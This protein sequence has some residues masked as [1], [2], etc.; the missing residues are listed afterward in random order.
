[1]PQEELDALSR[2]NE[3]DI[4]F[5]PTPQQ[6]YNAAI[7]YIQA[8]ISILPVSTDGTKAPAWRLLPRVK[9]ED[10]PEGK[11]S[12]RVFQER[13]PTE[14]EVHSW[15]TYWGPTPGI[16][17]IGGA[18]SGGLGIID[19][20]SADL[21]TP[22]ADMVQSRLPGVLER[23]VF[24]QTPRPGL[25]GYYRCEAETGNEKLA[26]RRVVNP[27]TEGSEV[28]TLIET[29]GNGGYAIVP[30][31]PSWC[32][33]SGRR[34]FY[35]G[36]RDL[37]QV[38]VLTASE[39]DVLFEAGRRLNEIVDPP[40][41]C[42]PARISSASTLLGGDRPGDEFNQDA[43][44]GDLLGRHGW[45]F[46]FEDSTGTGYWRRPGKTTGTSATVNYGSSDR[47][48]IFSENA[49]PLESNRSYSKFEFL[50][51]VEFGG[52]FGAASRWLLSQGYGQRDRLPFGRRRN[53]SHARR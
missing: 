13:M 26:R 23:L 6:V 36:P 10:R 46:V 4:D 25:H 11:H 44:W 9:T 20:D 19:F 37:T 14:E 24:V 22:F 50:A 45:S 35:L 52:D 48:Y 38:S 2:E 32:H 41:A 8:G 15:F 3:Q 1:M 5:D 7:E 43:D 51:A 30:P 29:K 21:F 47:L 17:V 42:P 53:A 12:W 27:E 39:R 18:I 31:S 49:H 34:Y 40:R 33:P 16:A 28:K